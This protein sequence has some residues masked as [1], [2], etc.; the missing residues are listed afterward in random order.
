MQTSLGS[1]FVPFQICPRVQIPKIQFELRFVR[2]IRYFIRGWRMRI[3]YIGK[4]CIYSPFLIKHPQPL[5][6]YL[7]NVLQYTELEPSTKANLIYTFHLLPPSL[8]LSL[9]PFPTHQIIV[10][11]QIAR[12]HSRHKRESKIH[13]D[14]SSQIITFVCHWQCL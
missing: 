13:C 1:R 2:Y 8:S 10:I 5:R 7:D 6:S 11:C 9:S 14:E 4:G 3:I 12:D